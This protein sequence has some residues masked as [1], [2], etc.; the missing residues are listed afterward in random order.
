MR[1]PE[2]QR[3]SYMWRWTAALAG[4]AVLGFALV[5]AIVVTP[6]S[7]GPGC[8]HLRVDTTSTTR[9]S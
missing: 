8:H 7:R 1:V 6:A 3:K 2:Q 9:D 5:M 4:L